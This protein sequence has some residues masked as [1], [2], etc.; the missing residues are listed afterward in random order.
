MHSIFFPVSYP[1]R[2]Y[3]ESDSPG[4]WRMHHPHAVVPVAI[5][6]AGEVGRGQL[7]RVVVVPVQGQPAAPWEGDPIDVIGRHVW[8]VVKLVALD[9]G[10]LN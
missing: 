3:S 4:P 6:V 1:H 7:G 5:T 8:V 10:A 9:V 2:V